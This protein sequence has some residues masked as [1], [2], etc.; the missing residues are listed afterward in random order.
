MHF[1]QPANPLFIGGLMLFTAG[2]SWLYAQ[3]QVP[4]DA[5][6][7]R[8]IEAVQLREL[9][10]ELLRIHGE[11]QRSASEQWTTLRDEAAPVL[12]QRFAAL[13]VMIQQ[14][15]HEALKYAFSPEL[16]NDLAARFPLFAS[17]LERHGAWQ[18]PVELWAFDS[19]D[20]K[21]SRSALMMNVGEQIL[22]V[23]F[24]GPEP[25]GLK[26]G[27]VLEIVGVQVGNVVVA[28]NGTV[29]NSTLA[30]P[31]TRSHRNSLAL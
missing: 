27:A 25:R 9:N 29:H 23:H 1:R 7:G 17:Y 11:M 15:P 26:T 3:E 16:A 4:R 2:V 19:A 12:Q 8:R 30:K 18:G 5:P 13:S 6:A 22:E 14:N 10:N 21:S 28:F 24:A 31:T 20:L